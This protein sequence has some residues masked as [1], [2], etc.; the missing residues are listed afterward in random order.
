KIGGEG[1]KGFYDK[2]I[3]DFMNKYTKKWGGKVGE[4][5]IKLGKS[6][7]AN[8]HSLDITDAMRE[9]VNEG[10]PLFKTGKEK[11]ITTE[12]KIRVNAITDR[13]QKFV[14]GIKTNFV[15]DK[16]FRDIFKK[17]GYE[18]QKDE[19]VP[20]G[21]K[22]KGETYINMD[23]AT[24][25]TPIHEFG[26]IWSDI[27]KTQKPGLYQNGLKIIESDK[28][29]M[30]R[31]S[32]IEPDLKEKYDAGNKEP[33]L[34]EMLSRAIEKPGLVIFEGLQG[35]EKQTA[36]RQFNDWLKRMWEKV[37]GIFVERKMEVEKLDLSKATL[38]EFS[39]AVAKDLLSGKKYS[40]ITSEELSKSVSERLNN[41]AERLGVL[42]FMRKPFG[43]NS[44]YVGYS[45]SR[46]AAVAYEE[47]KLTYSKLPVWAKRMVDAGLATTDEWH[48]T[49]S[50]G[51]ETPFYN[52]Q[53]FF[54]KL[55][56]AEKKTL[57]I[58][59][60]D[61][62]ESFKDV[63]KNVIK[64]ID[65]KSKEALKKK[66]NIKEVRSGFV[67]DA[68]KELD[69][70]NS[71]FKTFSRESKVPEN[72]IVSKSEMN[73]KYG[74]FESTSR[75][76][77]PEYKSGIDYE[78]EAN[79][80]KA[81]E[82]ENKLGVA[83]TY[84][85]YK[86]ELLK[87]G[88]EENIINQLKKFNLIH[89]EILPETFYINAKENKDF[90]TEQIKELSKLPKPNEKFIPQFRKSVDDFLTDEEKQARQDRHS[91]ISN[92]GEDFGS[93]YER[94][95]AHADNDAEYSEIAY[96]RWEKAQKEFLNSDEVKIQE[97]KFNEDKIKAEDILNNLESTL[98]GE[99]SENKKLLPDESDKSTFKS[100]S[101]LKSVTD[102][103]SDNN[104]K[105][106]DSDVKENI[107]FQRPDLAGLTDADLKD[108]KVIEDAR[109]EWI[110][111]GTESKYFKNWFKDS[112][113]VDESGKPLVV[114]HG[115][116]KSFNKFSMKKGSQG[117]MWF[118]NDKEAIEKGEVGASDKGKIMNVYLDIKNPAGWKEYEKLGLGQIEDL[119]YD[120]IILEEKD[121]PT[122]YIVFNPEQIKSA[123]GNIGTFDK[124]NPDIRFQRP[125]KEEETPF[126]RLTDA[127]IKY[128]KVENLPEVPKDILK[129]KTKYL[130]SEKDFNEK[131]DDLKLLSTI[132]IAN[133]KGLKKEDFVK[134]LNGLMSNSNLEPVLLKNKQVENLWNESKPI[135]KNYVKEVQKAE[136]ET[137]ENKKR[138]IKSIRQTK[139]KESGF[140][141][142]E[143]LTFE[144]FNRF[145]PLQRY[146]DEKYS[147]KDPQTYAMNYLNRSAIVTEMVKGDSFPI[148]QKDGNFKME[149]GTVKD[150]LKII[151]DNKL[152]EAEFENFLIARRVLEDY[153]DYDRIKTELDEM[154][155]SGAKPNKIAEQKEK[156][157]KKQKQILTD[158]FD[159]K[160]AQQLV[161][162]NESKYKE[163][164]TQYDEIN[165]RLLTIA[166]NTGLI[167]K[168]KADLYR[169]GKNYTSFKRY[170][171]EIENGAYG[172]DPA[173][174]LSN[175]KERK[176]SKDLEII[177]PIYSQIKAIQET[178]SKGFQ[179]LI[180]SK[181]YELSL[182]N[183]TL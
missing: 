183:E 156:L 139:K 178:V 15:S 151:K 33:L 123:T 159:E 37:K 161:N 111:K 40:D 4:G 36:I 51:N 41:S 16:Q 121:S 153:R 71:K 64:A 19:E 109:K 117:V 50:Y 97:E 172:T 47:G 88:Y 144:N 24:P 94:R 93:S 58:E 59:D 162:D 29:L 176:G 100:K 39:N 135:A 25:D 57:G 98:Y 77:L 86:I 35:K 140:T 149:K 146:A 85:I 13:L 5:L 3:H 78:T 136:N 163:V 2:I 137:V 42:E 60:I 23:K 179:N 115:T 83:E 108:K 141:A 169:D 158:N 127:Q 21:A 43:G 110:E 131:K 63:P 14:P 68:Q 44:G 56:E 49:S 160:Q 87:R 145:E 1:M 126:D 168:E 7:K 73:G 122:N 72:G 95:N 62:I 143:R 147:L 103:L 79:K 53:Q 45:M 180:W 9:S 101:Q 152:D 48:H 67:N 74:W 38:K 46:R 104:I 130:L 75:Y 113:V 8:I 133:N 148:L 65:I 80:Q 84:P 138:E 174:K 177:S 167:D 112:K 166:E 54:E 96:K 181:V 128:L 99:E 6:T 66:N 26:H 107:Q 69:D 22:Y 173:T 150:Y 52:V 170:I 132:I 125:E 106:L 11:P 17:E 20:L 120:G 92:Q 114:Y 157:I 28:M 175:M 142:Y 81:T 171:E 89:S 124:A 102:D 119:K 32:K 10:Q 129:D 134:A 82:L 105:N 154:I 30:D 76:N 55:T 18:F 118:T 91:F 90:V 34:D 61:N 31:V 165:K 182:E 116:G 155:N 70:F 27:I 12:T 164:T